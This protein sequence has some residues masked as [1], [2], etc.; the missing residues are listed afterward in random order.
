M[1]EVGGREEEMMQTQYSYIKSLQ[2]NL[3]LN[4]MNGVEHES[5]VRKRGESGSQED[6]RKGWECI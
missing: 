3:N 4:T 6:R 2:N 1:G 5:G